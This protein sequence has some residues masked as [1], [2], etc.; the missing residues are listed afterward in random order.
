[1]VC[2][3]FCSLAC[4]SIGK[5]NSRTIEELKRITQIFQKSERL[6]LLTIVLLCG[7]K[8]FQFPFWKVLSVVFMAFW[9]LFSSNCTLLISTIHFA[10]PHLGYH[11]E[12]ALKK[13]PKIR[14]KFSKML[15]KLEY[16]PNF[17]LDPKWVK[18]LKWI[19]KF[20]NSSY[21]PGISFTVLLH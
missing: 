16:N 1:M 15:R 11:G 5:T 17:D 8:E 2:F 10:T 13:W 20:K 19:L 7:N 3:S 6:P 21:Y 12:R 18:I 9:L 4:L 14:L